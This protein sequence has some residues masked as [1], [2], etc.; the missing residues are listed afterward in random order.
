MKR[1]TP[2]LAD[3][4]KLHRLKW[5]WEKE[6]TGYSDLLSF[7]TADMDY[8]TP[9]PVLKALDDVIAAGHLGYP[10]VKEEFYQAIRNHYMEYGWDINAISS[11]VQHIGIYPAAWNAIDAFTS[12]GDKITIL[13]PVHFCFRRMIVLNDRIPIEC[14]LIYSNGR[15]SIDYHALDACLGSGS[16]MLWLCNPHNPIGCAWKKDELMEIAQLAEK[17]GTIILTDDVYSGLLFPGAEYTPIA[18]LS[19]EISYR[20]I[21]LCST[22]KCYNTTGLKHAYAI[23]E[24]PEMFKTYSESLDRQDLGYGMNIMG[25]A[26]VIAAYGECDEWLHSLMEEISRKHRFVTD[27]INENIPALSVTESNASYFAWIDMRSLGMNAK[28]IAYRLET[29]EHM[30]FE[31][32]ADLGKGGAGFIRMNLATSDMNIE[33]GMERLKAF[34]GRHLR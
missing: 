33:R 22:S 17:H 15:Y 32:G 28:E 34:S 11:V 3:D 20:T 24:N 13:T 26:A 25:M 12:P 27:F 31:N 9:E 1:E 6:K 18:S 8:R 2:V 14:P 4:S 16:R 19:K 29:E 5:E 23:I 10:M 7:G 30:V 21:T